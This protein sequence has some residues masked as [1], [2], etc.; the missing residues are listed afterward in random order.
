MHVTQ[1]PTYLVCG[2][3]GGNRAEC[4]SGRSTQG[5]WSY[6]RQA[7]VRATPRLPQLHTVFPDAC[8]SE[9]KG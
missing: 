6:C 4:T 9:T 5:Q 1:S 8:D 2:G 3:D 7:N